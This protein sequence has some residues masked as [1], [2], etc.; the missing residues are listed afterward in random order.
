M[1]YTRIECKSHGTG[2]NLINGEKIL[3]AMKTL[4]TKIKIKEMD[5]GTRCWMPL[6]SKPFAAFTL[7]EVVVA[8]AVFA[9]VAG[10]MINALIL[11]QYSTQAARS[12]II[13]MNLISSRIE[14]IGTWSDVNMRSM[15]NGGGGTTNIVENSVAIS[16]A[17]FAAGFQSRNTTISSTQNYYAV[18]VQVNWNERAMGSSRSR[19]DSVTT[20]VLPTQ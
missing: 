5:K 19:S 12:R 2:V 10:A 7:V 20:Y 3:L 15:V 17:A 4:L 9:L 16:D 8:T 6:K 13:A 18:T 11:T 14:D 1:L